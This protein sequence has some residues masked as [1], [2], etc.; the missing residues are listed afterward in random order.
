MKEFEGKIQY[1]NKTYRLPFSINVLEKLQEKYGSYD[2][3]L[4]LLMPKNGE[5]INISALKFGFAAMLNEGIAADNDENGTDVA[6]LTLD[7][8]G[9]IITDVGLQS[10]MDSITDAT[11]KGT[12]E[13]KNE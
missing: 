11:N 5:E 9:R 7:Q 3:W 4:E 6:L 10:T 13:E 1:K 12:K 2:K 8:V